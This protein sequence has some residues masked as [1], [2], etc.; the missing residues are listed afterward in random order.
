MMSP[1]RRELLTWLPVGFALVRCGKAPL[2]MMKPP[3]L[4]FLTDAEA[5]TLKSVADVVLPPNGSDLGAVQYVDALLSAFDDTEPKVLLG[6]LTEVVP[7]DRVSEKAWRLRLFGSDGVAGGAPN[8][9]IIGKTIGLRDQTRSA[10]ALAATTTLDKLDGDTREL[11]CD[12]VTQAAFSAPAYGG[13]LNGAGWTLIG[14]QGAVMPKGFT[15]WDATQM[16]NVELPDLPDSTPEPG[17]DAHPMD[18]FTTDLLGQ[19]VNATGGKVA[20]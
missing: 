11:L 15:Q 13:N 6:S 7:L 9:A 10:L 8:D 2:M 17:T 3:P 12:L 14:T 4:R 19:V 5:A 16:K 1:S 20:S 18:E